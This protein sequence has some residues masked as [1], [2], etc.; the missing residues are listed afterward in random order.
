MKNLKTLVK[1]FQKDES[2][3]TLV[4]Y[5]AA[6]GIV[7]LMG[8]AAFQGLSGQIVTNFTDAQTSLA[9]R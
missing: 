8:V 3:A 1:A 9:T 4:E 6:I 5:A 7:L 2:G